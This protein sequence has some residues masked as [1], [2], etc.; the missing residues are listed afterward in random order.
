M[1]VN[2]LMSELQKESFQMEPVVEMRVVKAV[3]Q[4]MDD[5]NGEVQNLAVKCLGP[6]VKQ[7]KEENLIYIIDRLNEYI[8]QQKRDELREIA[9]V[10][11]KTVVI[12]VDIGKSYILCAHI[13][14]NL[15]ESIQKTD[16][17]YDTQMDT[18]DILSEILVRFGGQLSTKQQIEIQK[19][20]LPLLSY[21]RAAV[22][23]RA[24]T[25]IGYLAIHVDDN[26][27][28]QIYSFLLDGLRSNSAS[29]DVTR[30]LVQCAGVISRYNAARIGEHMSEI[31]PIIIAF[32]PE[33]DEDDELREYCLQTLEQFILKCPTEVAPHIPTIQS[34]ALEYIKYDPNFVE[35][36]DGDED[37][38]V[39]VEDDDDEFEDDEIID[40]ED[41]DD[42]MSWKVRRSAAK[43]LAAI[44]ATRP[45][46]LQ[47]L[48]ENIAPVLI[49]RFKEREESVRVDILQTF[50]TLLRQTVVYSGENTDYAKQ[51]SF[52]VFSDELNN[53][54]PCP[55]SSGAMDVTDGPRQLLQSQVA[56]LCRAL[57]KQSDAKS[58][59]TR[60]VS[61]H[62]LRE[63]I[64]VLH[65]GLTDQ[66]ELFYP[67]IESSL[68]T[69]NADQQQSSTNLKIEVLAFLRSFFHVHAT[70]DIN[71]AIQHLSPSVI[72]AL[73]DKFYKIVSEAF[74][75][76]M[77]IIK[78]IR[79]IQREKGGEYR[80][81][82]IDKEN[83]EYINGIYDATINIL[84]TS[85]ADQEVKE[86]SIM[87]LGTILSQL[88]D[89]LGAKQKEAWNGLLDRIRNEVTRVISIKTLAQICQSPVAVGED[90][91]QCVLTA[92]D[93]ITLLLRK[94]NRPL[95]IASL[96][97][98]SILIQKFGDDIPA[99]SI[100]A[101]LT[102]LKPL[103][104]DADLH[105]FPLTMK[106]V[107]SILTTVPTSV[108]E[109]NKSIVPHIIQ[110]IGSPLLQGAALDSLLHMLASLA[111][112]NPTDYHDL[113]KA[114]VDPLLT[115]K[116]A[117][118]ISAGGVAAVSNKQASSTVA[119]CV[120]VLA[121]IT[122]N[123]NCMHTVKEFKSYLQSPTAN[124][125]VKYLS[126]L[127]IGEIGRR[128]DLSSFAD[129]DDEITALFSSQSEE[130]KF[131]AAF[132][133]G[134][135]CVGNIS[136][137]L[138]SIV[139]QIKHDRKRRYLLLHALKEVITRYK[140]ENKDQSLSAVADEIWSLLLESSENNQEE[141]TRTVVAE[142]LGKLALTE[143]SKFLPQLEERLSS[144]S[145]QT[146]AI[147]AT[148][149]KYAV[150]DPSNDYDEYLRPIMVRF[151][152]LMQDSD[153]NVR[154]LTLLTINSAIHRKPYL[155]RGVLDQLIPL[156]YAETTVK[157][158]LI[159][160]VEMGPFKHQ[161]DDG[162]EIRKAAF[163][164]MYTLLTTCFDK[165]DIFGFL[166][167]VK[168][169]LNDQHDIKMLAYLML[170]RLSKQAPAAVSQ[171]LD[172]F[173]TPLKSTLEFKMRSN[174]VKQEVEKN[175]ELIR[176]AL[177]CI[178]I[179]NQLSDENVS[180][181]FEQLV[182]DIKEGPL[183]EDFKA[184]FAEVE[185][186]ESRA[187]YMEIS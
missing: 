45:D 156:L 116:A 130:V 13:I 133:L 74:L 48:Y 59:Q 88:G 55:V 24:T 140:R 144:E 177:R 135:I 146:R 141:G 162:L 106:A 166:E 47:D 18:L 163:E 70:Y 91:K 50:I 15:L 126:L 2:D 137:Y 165:I 41:D 184:I 132:A 158:E 115:F 129:I 153:L 180:P 17:P 21:N 138:P 157:Q 30:T 87:C 37:M 167:H 78:A 111:K 136:N 64:N 112:A 61:F 187:E 19:V 124:D 4:L 109:V 95:R 185:S 84:N 114:L 86:R 142:C 161:V 175:Q 121:A 67:A 104:S 169:G 72:N 79:P 34:L 159:H 23:K 99:N 103:V 101:L 20:L 8:A 125:S 148:A 62:L 44:I 5:K 179:L 118:G 60:Q 51:S 52:G 11:L 149:I 43:V 80:I 128:T 58:L 83:I 93:E 100:S 9:S 33:A 38:G 152:T 6:L 107:E 98:L 105:L 127:I 147:V 96:E 35:D 145:A 25:A 57:A 39:E 76:C 32:I 97:C 56:K 172:E 143:P 110:L 26:V 65:G 183:K 160:T 151:L 27:F 123:D 168:G 14:P 63:L 119:Q 92:V 131:A 77:E 29:K 1:A 89:S 36:E 182:E 71:K 155:A 113:V 117:S 134:N 7:I 49:N 31:I 176:G 150:V 3:M 73:S 16:I 90:M 108:S 69:A 54:P 85:D 22:R 102:E 122:N 94:N 81:S 75:V 10:G 12:E 173:V 181:R 120:A 164:C 154:R 171:S 53:L 42:D 174:A 178:M 40:Y 68:S 82:S 139:E 28:K 66:I 46:R 170:T 186:R